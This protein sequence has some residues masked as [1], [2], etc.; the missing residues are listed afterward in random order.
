MLAL[1]GW[2]T[3]CCLCTI[4]ILPFVGWF[5]YQAPCASRP[6]RPFRPHANEEVLC[7]R[8]S[9]YSRWVAFF[10]SAALV[11]G[12]GCTREEEWQCGWAM[13][14]QRNCGGKCTV[15]VVELCFNWRIIMSDAPSVGPCMNFRWIFECRCIA[16]GNLYVNKLDILCEEGILLVFFLLFSR[17]G[18]FYIFSWLIVY[19]LL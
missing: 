9:R 19:I 5:F 2:L 10:D 14:L 18:F 16:Y 17:D 7:I 3:G 8:S 6:F 4:L 13:K 1:A 11:N 15:H 12:T